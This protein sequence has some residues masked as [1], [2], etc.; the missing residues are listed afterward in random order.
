[1]RLS[2]LCRN[3]ILLLPLLVVLIASLVVPAFSP[4]ASATPEEPD[5]SLIDVW[6]YGVT[7]GVYTE[8]RYM[9]Q[10]EGDADAGPSWTALY[11]DGVLV[12]E[13]HADDID[14]GTWQVETFPFSGVCS[15]ASDEFGGIA[16]FYDEIKESDE[17]NNDYYR[18]YPC[19]GVIS[20]PDLD[21]YYIWHEGEEEYYYLPRQYTAENNI[22]F[23][24]SSSGDATS[25]STEAR[26]YVD[27]TWFSTHSIPSLDPGEEYQGG[28]GYIGACSGTSDTIRV[29]VD[30]SN[31]ITELD[32]TN[33]E[34]TKVW[35]CIV[36]PPP[37]EIPDLH[38]RS[39]WLTPV[40]GG[41]FAIGYTI[42]NLGPGYAPYSSTGLYLDDDFRVE[43]G[44]DR[45]APGEQRDEE[46]WWPYNMA[47]CT[48]PDDTMRVV[49]DYDDGIDETNEAN[50]E[51]SLT[52]DC[53]EPPPVPKPDLVILT[54]WYESDPGLFPQDLYIWY[55]IMNQGSEPAGPSVTRLYINYHEIATSDVPALD[56]GEE[57]RVTFTT[58]WTPQSN[59]NYLQICA[60]AYNDVDEITPEPSGEMN[61]CLEE[62]WIFDLSCHDGIQNRDEEGIDCEGAI[63]NCPPCNRCDLATLPSRFDWRDYYTLPPIRNQ[64]LCGSCWAFSAVGAVE[65]T[66]VVESGLIINLSEQ[67]AVSDCGCAGCCGGGFAHDVLNYIISSGIVDEA[68][69]AYQSQSCFYDANPSPTASDWRCCDAAAAV[70]HGCTVCTCDGDCANP[71]TCDRCVN[72]STSQ[73][74]IAAWADLSWAGGYDREDIKRALICHGPLSV[75]SDNWSHCVVIVGYNDTDSCWIIRN[76]WGVGYGTNGYGEIPYTGHDYSDIRDYVYYVRGVVL[77]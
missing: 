46:F 40:G 1:M 19:P 73:W 35:D 44:V 63:S 72:W 26:L 41:E 55:S 15:G 38:I 31:T 18:T 59:D 7:P 53:P 54:V 27:D 37:G 48:S 28:F 13:H 70:T 50:N 57:L 67:E 52:W 62:D 16:D 49:A 45:L 51:Y 61:N 60:D 77:P 12:G 71:C 11:I 21:L 39:V 66:Y 65:C 36:E 32:E 64:A 2:G 24:V 4:P 68:C 6:Y 8:I 56:P 33:N 5:L 75:C 58:R 25:P 74:T 14:A 29:V 9:L 22:R 20:L 10:N 42:E 69:F 34:Q 23:R 76:S 43:D 30:P 3:G 47:T 17:T